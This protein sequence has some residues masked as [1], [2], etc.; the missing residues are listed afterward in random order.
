MQYSVIIPCYKSSKTIRGVVEDTMQEFEKMGRTPVEFILVDDCSPDGGAT[1]RALR[2]LV[3]DYPNVTAIELAANSGQHNAQ[4]AGL[5]H[6]KGDYIISMDDDGQTR[7]SQLPYLFAELEKG[8]DVVYAYYPQ[9]EHSRGRNLGTWFNQWSL[10]ILMG[11]PKELKISSFWVIRRFVRDYAVRY[12]S[13]Y[14]R[15][16]GVFLR[17]TR[18]I[19]SVPV[20]H[21]KREEGK[22]GYTLK[23]LIRL[24]QNIMAFSVGPLQICA[25]VGDIVAAAGFLGILSVLIRRLLGIDTA[26]GWSSILVSILFFSGLILMFLGLIGT[27]LGRIYLVMSDTP[28]FVV[29]QIDEQDAAGGSRFSARRADAYET[30]AGGEEAAPEEVQD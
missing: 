20:Q 29:R 4:M 22:S 5:N 13:P 26:L 12:R 24:W 21:F 3:Q 17:V 30:A 23:K 28:Q 1:V 2:S 15:M 11:K 6:A 9:K 10:R 25:F 18:N 7:A 27:Y 14:T 8:Y 19:S 16:S